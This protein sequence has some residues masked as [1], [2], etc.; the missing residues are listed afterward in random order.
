MPGYAPLA[1]ETSTKEVKEAVSKLV[2]DKEDGIDKLRGKLLR[3]GLT[4]DSAILSCLHNMVPSVW[5]QEL[6]S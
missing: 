5:R 6:L 1:A 3:L 4:E 2:N